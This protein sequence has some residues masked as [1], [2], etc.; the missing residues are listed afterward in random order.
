MN[1]LVTG[2]SGF[3]GYHLCKKLCNLKG[4]KVIGIDNMNKYYDVKLKK[5]RLTDLKNYKNF[6]FFKVDL[7]NQTNLD[8]IFKKNKLNYVVNLAAQAGVRHSIEEPKDYLDSNINGFFNILELSKKYKIKHLV[9]ASTSSVYGD[10]NNFP[11]KEKDMINR[12]LSFYAA[13]KIGNEAMAHSYSHIHKLP[14]TGLR[15]FTVY[16]P[17]GRPDMALFNFIDRMYKSKHIYLYNNGDHIRDFTYVDDVVNAISKIIRK[18][19]QRK[20]PYEVYN[21]GCSKPN[22]L[23]SFLQIIEKNTKIKAKIK[24]LGLQRGDTHK[25]HASIK[26][27]ERV[28]NYKPKTDIKTGIKKFIDWYNDY[29]KY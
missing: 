20:N 7:K 16:G 1:I 5:D 3:I 29:F 23:K 19:S 9:F 26:K 28:I 15:F 12:P 18:P 25:T 10:S 22:S 8:T 21:V 6:K 2:S 4:C 27:L 14:C 17:F 11:T 24:Y 13:T